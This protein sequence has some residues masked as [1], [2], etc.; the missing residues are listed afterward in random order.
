MAKSPHIKPPINGLPILLRPTRNR[1]GREAS[2]LLFD[3]DFKAVAEFSG[4]AGFVVA[5]A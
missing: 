2:E 4:E 5:E 1:G 3:S